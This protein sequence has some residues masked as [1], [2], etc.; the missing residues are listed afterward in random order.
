MRNKHLSLQEWQAILERQKEA[1]QND[2]EWAQSQGVT[3]ANSTANLGQSDA[4]SL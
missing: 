4:S 1:K 3:V 2:T